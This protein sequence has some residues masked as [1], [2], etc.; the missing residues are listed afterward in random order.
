[1]EWLAI[2]V[3][4][5]VLWVASLFK[6]LHESF[7]A[8]QVEVLNDGS[9]LQPLIICLCEDVICTYYACQPVPQK[10]VKVL[11]HPDLQDGFGK[12]WN[13][14]LLSKI[15]KEEIVNCAIDLVIT[16]DNY[17]VSGHCNHQDVHQGVRE[18]LQDTSHK[19][20]EVWELVSTSILRK[21]TGPV[22]I[23]L[24]LLSAK[25]HLSG[26]V[27]CFLNEYPRRSLAAMAQHKSQ[28]V[29][30][31]KLFVSFSSYTYVNCLRKI[32]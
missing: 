25:F 18:L 10:Q 12:S 11:D 27:H 16:F 24:S 23:W 7:S 6:I 4:M 15:I 5:V 21:Y 2:I 22:D 8:S 17:G 13:S 14:K 28:W 9:L 31:R 30:F 29:W 1:M 32:D 19:E 3:T 20:V 26:V